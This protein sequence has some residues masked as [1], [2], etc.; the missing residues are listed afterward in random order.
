MDTIPSGV[1]VDVMGTIDAAVQAPVFVVGEGPPAAPVLRVL[2]RA[3]DASAVGARLEAAGFLRRGTTYANF[4]PGEV[5]GVELLITESWG[6]GRGPTRSGEELFA[7]CQPLPGFEHLARPAPPV[8]LVL[9]AHDVALAGGELSD[10][11]RKKALSAAGSGPGVWDDAAALAGRFRLT[12]HLRLLRRALGQPERWTARQRRRALVRA[13]AAGPPSTA[14][15]AA[16]SLVRHR[17]RPLLVS[18]SGPDGSGKST[19]V[20]RLVT[21]LDALGVRTG[22]AWVP[23]TNRPTLPT[24]IRAWAASWRRPTG[25]AVGQEKRPS[26]GG[27]TPARPRSVP[28]HVR[29]VEHL[30]ITS[31]AVSNAAKIW[32]SVW[33]GRGSDVLV[34]DRFVLDADVKLTY[35]YQV[36][37]GADITMERRLF[38][39]VCPKVD[40]SVL[41]VVDPETNVA[42]RP[43]EWNIGAFRHFQ[44]IYADTARELGAVVVDAER[45]VDDVARDIAET[46][47]TRLP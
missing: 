23:T 26:G 31:A 10:D 46:V 42:R 45:P 38:R 21:T 41:L 13:V 9:I 1:V 8:V 12:A 43:D 24:S 16:R 27:T 3:T 17:R 36:R 4:E 28:P 18:L 11:Q 6:L 2:L 37:R 35:W 19:Q 34:L 40:V 30:W 15:A 20:G 25:D 5:Q 22:T 14:V 44:K 39:A 33:R 32:A 47:W 29:L 7:G